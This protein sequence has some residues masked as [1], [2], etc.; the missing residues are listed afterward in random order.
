MKLDLQWSREALGDLKTLS[1]EIA[2]RII[3]K[4]VWFSA[5]KDPLNHATSLTGV[6]AGVYRF[7]VGDYRVLFEKNTAGQLVVLLILRVK[8]RREV[9]R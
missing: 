4:V 8:H 1:Q 2:D 7:R 6:Y 9:Y 5:Q 3:K